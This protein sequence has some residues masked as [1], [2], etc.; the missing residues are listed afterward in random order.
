MKDI[1]RRLTTLEGA[2]EAI[3]SER[4]RHEPYALVKPV[5]ILRDDVILEF[6]ERGAYTERPEAHE[7]LSLDEVLEQLRKRPEISCVLVS[8][9]DCTEWLH[10]TIQTSDLYTAEQKRRFKA[11][12]AE[13]FEEIRLLYELPEWEQVVERIS[14]W[15]QNG[16]LRKE[17]LK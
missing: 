1:E 8:Y 13:Q 6:Y 15:P 16:R 10:S 11:E 2:A 7:N 4:R 9:G 12:D 17:F 5:S 3:L 14:K